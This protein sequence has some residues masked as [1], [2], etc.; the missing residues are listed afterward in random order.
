MAGSRRLR[1]DLA[2]NWQSKPPARW[3]SCILQELYT[4]VHEI[5]IYDFTLI[6]DCSSSDF[7]VSDQARRWSE[8]EIYLTLGKPITEEVET[9]GLSPLGPHAPQELIAPVKDALFSSLTF[10]E[11]NINDCH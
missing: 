11:E 10:L 4:E 6:D 9:I 1:G 7:Q 5:Y 2:R 8:T 3:S